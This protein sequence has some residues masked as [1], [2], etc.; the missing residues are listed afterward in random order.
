MRDPKQFVAAVLHTAFQLVHKRLATSI[1]PP[2]PLPQ[3]INDG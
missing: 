1:V 2:V 3:N